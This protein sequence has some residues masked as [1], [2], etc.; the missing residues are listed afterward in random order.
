MKEFDKLVGVV[1]RLRNKENGC[2]WDIAQTSKS[3]IPNFV[4][5]IYEVIEAIESKDHKNLSLELGDVLLHILMQSE[6]ASEE[7]NFSLQDVLRGITQK[8]IQRHPHVFGKTKAKNPLDAK[9]SWE[10]SKQKEKEGESI[11]QSTPMSMP[12][13]ILASRLQEK[14]ASVGFNWQNVTGIIDKIQEEL[15]EL[16]TE[17]KAKN[18][19]KMEQEFGDL[20]FTLVNYA[21]FWGIDSQSALRGTCKKF[22]K[23]FSYIE[24]Y[25]KSKNKKIHQCNF[26]EL[27]CI[28]EK[29]KVVDQDK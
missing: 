22:K 14:V 21:N 17:V 13:L 10:R 20:L 25:C 3:L 15:D 28:W 16:R 8:L 11:L 7:K 27:N 26:A 29:S 19:L 9:N 24:N 4:E 5:E 1:K 23:R 12:A 18:K 2:P 6:I